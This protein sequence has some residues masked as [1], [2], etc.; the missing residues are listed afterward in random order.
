MCQNL[1]FNKVADLYQKF[2]DFIEKETLTQVFSSEFCEILMNNFLTEHLWGTASEHYENT[3]YDT[4]FET[5]MKKSV[6]LKVK[7]NYKHVAKKNFYAI[8]ATI[9]L[10]I[11]LKKYYSHK[12]L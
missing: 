3:R 1:F 6:F 4:L 8:F 9:D 12:E 10:S 7:R 11:A 2:K 5:N